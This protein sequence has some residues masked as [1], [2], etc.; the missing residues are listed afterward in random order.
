M[1]EGSKSGN[2]DPIVTYGMVGGGEGA[3]IGDVHRRAIGLDGKARLVAGSFSRS[4]ATT[5]ATGE[6]LHLDKDRLY[7]TYT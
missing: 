7:E 1:I 6:S 2:A 4:M 5:V 3:F